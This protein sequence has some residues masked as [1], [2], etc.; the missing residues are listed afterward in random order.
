MCFGLYFLLF[1]AAGVLIQLGYIP[2][3]GYLPIDLTANEFGILTITVPV[4]GVALLIFVSLVIVLCF[5]CAFGRSN[6]R[7]KK[8]L[9]RMRAYSPVM[10]VSNGRKHRN[11]VQQDKGIRR[12]W[13]DSE[14]CHPCGNAHTTCCCCN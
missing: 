7:N 14:M 8:A 5:V 2:I 13:N 12:N 1:G 4:F 11:R 3:T 9:H 10:N 6:H